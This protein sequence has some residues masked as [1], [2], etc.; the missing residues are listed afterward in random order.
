MKTKYVWE[1]IKKKALWNIN[2]SNLCPADSEQGEAGWSVT[3]E[4]SKFWH[5]YG[6]QMYLYSCTVSCSS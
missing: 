2:Y 5:L 1:L 4:G 6:I 3:W